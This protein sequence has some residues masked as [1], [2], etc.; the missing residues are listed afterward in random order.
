MCEFLEVVVH[1]LYHYHSLTTAI[2]SQ[3]LVLYGLRCYCHFLHLTYLHEDG[4]VRC[5]CLSFCRHH[6]QLRV[7]ISE[8][9]SN[10]V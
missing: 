8:V 7:E 4:V 1:A 6:L 10:K 9:R 2:D 5:R 3:G